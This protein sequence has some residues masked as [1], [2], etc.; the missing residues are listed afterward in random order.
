MFARFSGQ[1]PN[2][3]V[4]YLLFRIDDA[5]LR[6]PEFNGKQGYLTKLVLNI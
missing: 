4:Y 3:K 5:I 6:S 1:Y 2:L